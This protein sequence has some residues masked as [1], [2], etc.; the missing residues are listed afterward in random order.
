MARPSLGRWL[1][2]LLLC[3]AVLPATSPR[4]QTLT[5]V[6]E[7]EVVTLDPHFTTAYISRTFGYMVF[8][9]LFGMDRSG[10]PRPQM[11]ESWTTSPDGLTWR[12][13]PNWAADVD[14][15]YFDH[16]SKV[17]GERSDIDIWTVGLK[18]LW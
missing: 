1:A 6:L 2:F 5:A 18:Y 14:Y 7:A 15:T 3:G 10:T 11:V 12:F 13:T 4:A 9:T 8:D 16:T 17:A